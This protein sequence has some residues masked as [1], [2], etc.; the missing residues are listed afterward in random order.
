MT[1]GVLRRVGLALGL[2]IVLVVAWWFTSASSTDFY[3][4]PLR[5]ILEV[6]PDTWFGAR[7]YDDVLPSLGRLGVGYAAA[8]VL[9]IGIG[10]AIGSSRWLR[11]LVEPL[12]EFLRAI[13]PPVL[14]PILVLIAGIGN[15]MK[16]LVIISGCL[17]P[18]LLNAVEG[19][20][21]V[22]EVLADTCRSYRI[23]GRLRWWHLVLRSASPQIV[24]GARQALSVGII[25]MV[26]SEMFAASSGIGF[27]VI[28]FKDGF[29]IPQ[30]WSGVILL[31]LLGVLLSVLFR[32]AEHQVLGWY[33][34]SRA[35]QKER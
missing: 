33:H 32:I 15:T 16:I 4:P 18:V 22:D 24:A 2:P 30:M 17:W 6:F 1:A 7:M 9:G 35:Q 10:M 27:T 25:L 26:I 8:L 29:Q 14:V 20:R 31:G 28:Q 23:R 19:V 11:A 3:F 12:L 34:G 5:K 21:A 13:P